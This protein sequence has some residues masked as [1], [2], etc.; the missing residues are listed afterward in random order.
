MKFHYWSKRIIQSAALFSVLSLSSIA[1]LTA[2]AADSS[3]KD[4]SKIVHWKD[5]YYSLA[6]DDQGN[7]WCLALHAI[8]VKDGF[9]PNP[10]VKATSITD[11][12]SSASN[13]VLKNDGTVWA[14]ERTTDNEQPDYKEHISAT[15]GERIPHLENIVKVDELGTIVLAL[16][17]DGKVWII[18]TVKYDLTIPLKAEP[19]LVEG[20]DHV[21]DMLVSTDYDEITFLKEDGTVWNIDEYNPWGSSRPLYDTIRYTKPVQLE[22]LKDIVQLKNNHYAIKNDGTVWNWGRTT[23]FFKNRDSLNVALTPAAPY[24]IDEL[25][26]VVDVSS[27][28]EHVLFVKKDGTV[29]GKGYFVEKWEALGIEPQT[30]WKELFKLMALTT[31]LQLILIITIRRQSPLSKEMERFGCG[32]LITS[33][34]ILINH[35]K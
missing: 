33:A 20:I 23:D 2:T 1:P 4:Q 7:A 31:L 26:D 8:S 5:P 19:V 22:N 30:V 10:M 35:S 15:L 17:R 28:F 9:F 34:S 16:D 14:V 18:E 29:W 27:N 32:D 12:K 21:K 25:S 13:V 24:Q 3:A 11:V 6:I